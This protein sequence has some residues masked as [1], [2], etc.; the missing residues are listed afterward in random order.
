MFGRRRR[1][2]DQENGSAEPVPSPREPAPD[3]DPQDWSADDVLLAETIARHFGGARVEGRTAWLGIG[4]LRIDCA[5]TGVQQPGSYVAVSLF[6]HLAGG[7][8]GDLPVFASASGYEHT[9]RNAVVA[10]GCNWACTFGPV[11]TASL[12]GS[13]LDDPDAEQTEL[14]GRRFAVVL[15]GM[16]RALTAGDT[17][18]AGSL[19]VAARR[20]LA[21]EPFL[22]PRVLGSPQLPLLTADHTVLSVFVAAG[23]QQTTYEVK[24]NG[25]DWP[26]SR[27]VGPPRAGAVPGAVVLLRELAVVSA[28]E[29]APPL[30]RE[31]VQRTLDGLA[32]RALATQVAG[33]PGWAAHGGRLG[34]ALTQDALAAVESGTGLLPAD[35]RHFLGAVAGSG[36]GPGYGLL[37]PS[38]V[39]D[40]IP[41]AHGGC[42]VTW[43]LHLV[44]ERAGTVWVDAGGSDGTVSQVAGSFTAWYLAWLDHAVRD[45]GAWLQ[46]DHRCCATTGVLDRF[47]RAEP[48]DGEPDG[49]R[50]L[51]QEFGPGAVRLTAFGGYLPPGSAADP[52]HGCVSLMAHFNVGPEVFAPGTLS[53]PR[54]DGA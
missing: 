13:P 21:G 47:L 33:W 54:P 48:S 31:P 26:P 38:R 7:G 2:R 1:G 35:Y 51:S 12:G 39:G 27:L 5:V 3:P 16:D 41:L 19:I 40:V 17:D 9:V 18:D 43:V 14:D 29:P 28:L 32:M 30:A 10:G 8:L 52:C 50:D 22:T 6:F 37:P 45:C 34:P 46:W 23:P 11:L 25:S 49:P 53:R 36:A 24:V 42:G 20:D 15:S 4:D 44:G